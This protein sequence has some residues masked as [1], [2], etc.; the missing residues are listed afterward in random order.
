MRR[1]LADTGPL[2][3]HALARD[4]LHERA[5]AELARLKAERYT[6]VVTYSVLLEIHALIL[7]RERPSFA[8]QFVDALMAGSMMVNPGAEDY[9]AAHALVKRYADQTISLVDATLAV[10]SMKLSVPIWTFDADFDI[11][12]AQVWRPL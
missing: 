12:G 3:A 7:R 4:G 9:R 6:L 10:L 1:I 8:A 2:Y 11:L 5:K